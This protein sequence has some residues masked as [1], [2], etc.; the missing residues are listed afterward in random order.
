MR[1]K[2]IKFMKFGALTFLMSMSTLCFAQPAN[3]EPCGAI[4]LFPL[5]TCSFS[6]YDN[7]GATIT[8]TPDNYMSKYTNSMTIKSDVWFKIT[9]PASGVLII[10][11][12]AGTL[13]NA[14]MGLY[15]GSL[16]SGTLTLLNCNDVTN[17]PNNLGGGTNEMPII[18]QN[19][20][21]PLSTVWVRIGSASG[22]TGTFGVCVSSPNDLPSP[23]GNASAAEDCS[24]AS[25]V[26]NLKG[27]SGTTVGY[28]ATSGW[29]Q[30]LNAIPIGTTL[31]ND[32]WIK[33]TAA[34]T[35]INFNV[36]VTFSQQG[37]GFQIFLLKAATC[38]SGSVQLNPFIWT[39]ARVP[40]GS[41]NVSFTGL[42]I[43]QEYYVIFD[44]AYSDQSDFFINTPPD[45]GGL[46]VSN[47]INPATSEIC[48][49][50]NIDLTCIGGSGNYNW[51]VGVAGAGD[52]DAGLN[53]TSTKTVK[54]IPTSL[55]LH[56]Y[57]VTADLLNSNCPTL[58]GVATVNVKP[59]GVVGV[60]GGP[61]S[62]CRNATIVLT[63]STPGGVWSISSGNSNASIVVNPT[64]NECTLTG[65]LGGTTCDVKYSMCG[66][67][68]K[69][70]T[71][72]EL[73]V[74]DPI[75][76]NTTICVGSSNTLVS[77]PVAGVWS[78]A[79]LN[80]ATVNTSS[81]QVNAIAPGT[82]ALTY[83][84]TDANCSNS[85]SANVLISAVPSPGS[86]STVCVGAQKTFVNLT[87]GGVWNSL[88]LS[89]ATV[90][91][92]TGIVTGVAPGP[93][94]IT[95][96]AC[97]VSEP[98]STTVVDVPVAGSIQ[99]L[100]SF[101][102]G[103]PITLTGNNSTVGS[104]DNWVSGTTSVAT[105]NSTTGVVTSLS[106]GSTNI[107]YTVSENGCTSAPQQGNLTITSVAIIQ[108]GSSVCVGSKIT[109]TDATNGGT[110]S[111]VNGTGSASIVP[112][113]TSCELT[114]LTAGQVTIKYTGCNVM[115]KIIM[116][117]AL[118]SVSSITGTMSACNGLT[119]TL[120][121]SPANG[122]W[123]SD[124]ISV[125]TVNSSTGLVNAISGGTAN[126][127][128]TITDNNNCQNNS[129]TVFTTNQPNPVIADVTGPNHVY[130]YFNLNKD[131][132][133][134]TGNTGATTG[135]WS[136]I[137]PS[138]GGEATFF[139][140]SN[141]NTGIK[142]S[143]YGD[144]KFIFKELVCNNTDTLLVNFRP[145]AYAFVD[146]VFTVCTGTS[147]EFKAS[148]T[149]P[150][151]IKSTVWN[152]GD[153]TSSITVQEQG[154]YT[155][156]V[157]TGCGT[158]YVSTSKLF[159]KLCEIES[160]PNVITPNGDGVND[161]YKI[162]VEDGVFKTF[163]IVITNRWGSVVSEYSDPK[164]AWNGK[165]KNG[166]LVEEG[167]YFYSLKGETIE[168]KKI[169]KQGFIH[170]IYE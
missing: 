128:Y 165:T 41:V 21:T 92:S 132:M 12:K 112:N 58:P 129:T 150:E 142:I 84:I 19:N 29:S 113:G 91:S 17:T 170:V 86:V 24:G 25:S 167:V 43:G 59:T 61:S 3:D 99:G 23:S 110:W 45:G 96:T 152:T 117:N 4:E 154:I 46:A 140:T 133:N 101:C 68:T 121:S 48:L 159:V 163:D 31:Q 2:M 147:H 1:I 97:G 51:T 145:G 82:V 122:V 6:N 103:T 100:G 60:I 34:A 49:G 20:L 127:K 85:Q 56:T 146:S 66:E 33:V 88:D 116:V 32:S 14:Q 108:G 119:Q 22:T 155:L 95:Y 11:T 87:P 144:Y 18:A 115:S 53:S 54:A 151:Y 35:S 89:K 94:V 55:G 28:H 80:I 156:T 123:S 75:T 90:N 9:V 76:N 161:T 72:N 50:D 104:V 158:D 168:G 63:N 164:A 38:G 166:D 106:A 74:V 125:A 136:Y 10:E 149:Y 118:P 107:T 102:V 134:M 40:H 124:N 81:G 26:C 69:T 27:Y 162:E 36:W 39:P 42:T 130:C 52:P 62:V 70:I 15:S 138:T 7:I 137:P 126:I 139:S 131:T 79:D 160:M 135:L 111:I 57:N 169:T 67:S 77:G 37:Q 16:C 105:I 5:T 73:P 8:T 71:I 98:Y 83:T 153:I 44:G 143:K 120:A 47:S 13:T 114:G 78:S 65:I 157:S 148:F 30:L 93:V 109:F 64:T 141:F